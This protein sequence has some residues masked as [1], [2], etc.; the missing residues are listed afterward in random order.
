MIYDG[1]MHDKS[2]NEL[3]HL[4]FPQEYILSRL[5]FL[6][7]FSLFLLNKIRFVLIKSYEASQILKDRYIFLKIPAQN[8]HI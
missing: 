6:E 4:L 7:Y 2:V 1:K 3:N 5:I 8:S